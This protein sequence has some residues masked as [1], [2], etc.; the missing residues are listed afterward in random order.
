[1]G[2]GEG[3]FEE[4]DELE[5]DG[6]GYEEDERPSKGRDGH[7]GCVF[8]C[9]LLPLFLVE[10]L[11][12]SVGSVESDVEGGGMDGSFEE[13]VYLERRRMEESVEE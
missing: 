12:L 6:A 5:E 7:D 1:M 9:V 4:E 8:V 11:Y 3:A 2:R 13:S 10:A